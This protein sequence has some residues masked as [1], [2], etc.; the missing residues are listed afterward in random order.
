MRWSPTLQLSTGYLRCCSPTKINRKKCVGS[1]QRPEEIRTGTNFFVKYYLK[2]KRGMKE[3]L[4]PH[5]L[6]P[7]RQL[8]DYQMRQVKF[9]NVT[10]EF[11]N[12]DNP[13]L[14]MR[15]VKT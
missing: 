7:L 10:S 5:F 9:S 15:E 4:P 11:S 12:Y 8:F 3:P 13:N 1:A 14:Q 6:L 2:I